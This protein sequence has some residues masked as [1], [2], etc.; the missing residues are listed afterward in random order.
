MKTPLVKILCQHAQLLFRNMDA[1]KAELANKRKA[2]STDVARPAKYMRRGDIERIEQEKREQEEREKQLLK[3]Q[4]IKSKS[5]TPAVSAPSSRSQV[6]T[7]CFE[8]STL[9]SSTPENSRKRHLY[10]LRLHYP[11]PRRTSQRMILQL[12]QD[13]L[14]SIFLTRRPFDGFVPKASQSDFLENP[15]RIEDCVFALLNS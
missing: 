12:Q 8:H 10:H 5:T 1:L 7:I 3:E 15:T 4:N 14:R 11:H 2:L 9:I 6:G 13:L